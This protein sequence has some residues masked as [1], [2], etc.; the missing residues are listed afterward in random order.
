MRAVDEL[1]LICG[2]TPSEIGKM[3]IAEVAFW[4]QRAAAFFGKGGS[5]APGSAAATL[6]AQQIEQYIRGF[7]S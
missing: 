3:K 7:R 5:G 2:V 6:A 4:H 1:W